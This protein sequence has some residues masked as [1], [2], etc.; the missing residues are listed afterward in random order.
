[1]NAVIYSRVSTA[2]QSVS[3]QVN[4]LK[5]NHIFKDLVIEKVFSEA[6]S[7]FSKKLSEREQLQKMLK[8]V[9]ENSVEMIMVHEISRLGR[10]THETLT[11]LKKLEEDGIKLYI[12]NLGITLNKGAGSDDI[13][14]KLIVT[15]VSDLARLESEQLSYRIKSGI[16]ERKRRGLTTGRRLGSVENTQKFLNK[17][18]TKSIQK[19]LDQ[20]MSYSEIQKL[21]NASF[22]TISKVKRLSE[23]VG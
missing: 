4:D 9:N 22:S 19:Y 8:Y 13:F 7:G 5:K 2:Q 16:E 17:S 6:I 1:M 12:Y 23:Q 11:L 14:S 3:R 18:K 21:C 15:I 20:G 10:S